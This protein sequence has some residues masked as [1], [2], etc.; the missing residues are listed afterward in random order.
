MGS[1]P[2]SVLIFLLLFLIIASGFFSGS[3]I[4][5]MSLNRYRLRHWVRKKI[6]RAMRVQQLL[7]RPDRLLGVILIG[8]TFANILASAVATILAVRLMGDIGIAVSTIALTLVVLIFSEM[9]PKTVAAMYPEKVA[10]MVSLPLLILQKLFAPLVWL[11]SKVAN[12]FLRL[13]GIDMDKQKV[14]HLSTEELRTVVHET[15]SLIPNEHKKM[16]VNILDLEK[17][18]VEDIMVPRSE[19]LGIDLN[20]PWD[21]ILEQL[22]ASQHTR[23]PIYEESIDKAVGI[24]HLR[25]VAHALIDG[26]LNL[27][28]LTSLADACY[29]VPESTSLYSQLLNFRRARQRTG[30]VVDEYGDILG[31]VTLE[32]ILEEVIGEFTTDIG[33]I[34]RDISPQEDGSMVVDASITI[35]EL[36]RALKW[37]F[38]TNG[39]KTLSGV[40]IEHLEFIPPSGTCVK[41]AGHPIEVMQVHNNRIKSVRVVTYPLPLS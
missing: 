6:K 23:L 2:M 31:L 22:E 40:I 17:V 16:L 35:R 18:V 7:E 34:S 36:N 20:Q 12:A 5:M 4:G 33:D 41:I 27:E 14:E 39:P 26:T 10:F 1:W 29:Y 21:M 28:M 11:T 30:L 25:N 32:D 24:I 37:N 13:F 38:P 8:N 3:E 19:I 15:G 9:A